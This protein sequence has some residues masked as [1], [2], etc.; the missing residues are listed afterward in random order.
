[1]L[2]CVKSRCIVT[3]VKTTNFYPNFNEE[4]NMMKTNGKLIWIA[5][6]VAMSV[7]T[8]AL[9][10]QAQD[11][12]YS[13]RPSRQSTQ[14]VDRQY[15]QGDEVSVWCNNVVRDL[16]NSLQIAGMQEV[17]GNYTLSAET[18]IRGL[19]EANANQYLRK[20]PMTA[21]AIYRA[22]ELA[23]IMQR[24]VAGRA[25]GQRSV[26]EF[27]SQYYQ[28][29]IRTADHLDIPFYI[30]HMRGEMRNPIED[31]ETNFIRFAKDEVQVVLNTMTVQNE[32]QVF[33]VGSTAAF[34]NI[35]S[36]S[37]QF[38]SEDLRESPFAASY[39]CT[40]EYLNR[41]VSLVQNGGLG[42]DPDT[43]N[44]AYQEVSSL[45]DQI[46]TGCGCFQWNE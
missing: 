14:M 24:S 5:L 6:S 25:N 7:G 26:V 31:F 3:L 11:G 29:I 38:A 12:S 20:G 16:G 22:I 43:V 9:S 8:I 42:N 28:F 10:A 46:R 23:G 44:Y 4:M 30:P 40:I 35:L 32:G 33:P 17:Q 19:K 21:R 45:L 27:L 37:I 13:P 36:R 39:S 34:L 15:D 2:L 41:V 18:L 1:M